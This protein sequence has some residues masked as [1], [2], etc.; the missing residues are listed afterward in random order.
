MMVLDVPRIFAVFKG[1]RGLIDLLDTHQPDHGLSYNAV[2]MWSQ[3]ETIPGRWVAVVL[4]S[5]EQA[6]YA[7]GEFLTDD[8]GLYPI[9]MTDARPRR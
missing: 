5:I 1:P 8:M 6:G 9:R 7:W 3:R 2:Q 4:Y